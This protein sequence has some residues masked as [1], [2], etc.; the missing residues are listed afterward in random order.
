MTLQDLFVLAKR[1]FHLAGHREYV[2]VGSL[3]VLGISEDND[4][5]EEMSISNDIDCYTKDDPERIRDLVDALGEKSEFFS[6]H[7]FYLDPVTPALLTLPDGWEARMHKVERD[8]IRL[9]FLDANDAAISK[10]ARSEPRDLRWIR[11]GA[12]AG[13]V[14]MPTVRTR[15]KT[16]PFLDADEERRVRTRIDADTAWFNAVKAGRITP[17]FGIK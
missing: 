1:A 16:T 13:I 15:L 4:V 7:H 2:I 17:N 9:W 14:S 6:K 5:P 10:Y 3:S 8:S 12:A 11:A